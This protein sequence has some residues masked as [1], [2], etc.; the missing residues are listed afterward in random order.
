MLR[1]L[2]SHTGQKFTSGQ[3]MVRD[4]PL[5]M[6]VLFSVITSGNNN[7]SIHDIAMFF[8]FSSQETVLLYE[9]SKK[10]NRILRSLS[11]L[12]TGR[13]WAAAS[14]EGLLIYS[15]DA[16]LV[17]DPYDLDMDVTPT[18]IRRQLRKKEWT[19]A[20]VLAFRL[21]ETPLI[22]EVLETVPYNQSMYR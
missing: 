9:H 4:Q 11:V 20:I 3:H 14:T 6:S 18:S 17:F 12:Q 1:T 13:S 15:L 21:N 10:Q 22:R 16:S 19:S 5:K 8:G 7:T 2:N